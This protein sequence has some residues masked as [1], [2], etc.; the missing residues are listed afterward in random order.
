MTLASA[1]AAQTL[2]DVAALRATVER[3][4][5]RSER[6]RRHQLRNL[7]TLLET[8]EDAILEAIQID[9]GKPS[10]ECLMEVLALRQELNLC[11]RHLRRWMRPRRVNVPLPLRPGRAEVIPS[12]LG[13]VLIIGPWNYP[14]LLT[15]HPLIN[16]LAAGNTAVLKPS[17]HASTTAALIET[18]ISQTFSEDVVQV[19]QGDGATAASLVDQGYDHIFFTGGGGIGSKVLEGAARH[20][21]P[22]TLELGGKSPAVVLPGADLDVTARRL[23][24]GK[25]WNA[26]QTCIAPDYL[27]VADGLEAPLLAAMA[28]ARAD[29]YGNNP[30]ES[31]DLGPIIN[32][33]QYQRIEALLTTAQANGQVLIGGESD[34]ANRRIAPTVL[35]VTNTDDDPLMREEL[36]GPLLPLVS[37]RDL[38]EAIQRIRSQAKPLALY[39]FGGNAPQRQELLEGTSSGGVCFNDVLM[40]C[41]IPD[42]PFGGIGASGMGS[43]HGEAGFR[44]FSYERSVLHRPFALDL[45]LRYPPYRLPHGLMR[46]L[47][48]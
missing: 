20:L 27:L 46:R 38:Q 44:N 15:L 39:L 7:R 48:G 47:L 29:L 21:T 19:V 34:P 8:H 45:R 24:W 6:W 35:S 12:P 41:G 23:I 22:V 30:L 14:F 16:A 4:D 2:P 37:V 36:F 25:G 31:Q 11:E 17:E 10:T 9:L 40:H 33:R 1:P 26:G 32:T 5:T 13:C 43:Y 3:G 28:D 18:L 42:L